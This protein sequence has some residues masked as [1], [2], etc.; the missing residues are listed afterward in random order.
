M[1]L[2]L[3]TILF[4]WLVVVPLAGGL[5]LFRSAENQVVP[6]IS[7]ALGIPIV[8]GVVLIR[9]S[10]VVDQAAPKQRPSVGHKIRRGK[11]SRAGA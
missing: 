2:S 8:S 11:G 9:W 3:G 1:V 4:A 5:G 7:L 6:Y 10:G